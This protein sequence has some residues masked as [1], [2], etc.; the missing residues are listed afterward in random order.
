MIKTRKDLKF[1]LQE[2]A[3]A[4]RMEGCQLLKYWGRLFIGSESAH[5]YKYQKVLRHCEYHCNNGGIVNKMLYKYYKVRLYR[6]GFKYNIRIL[7]IFVAMVCQSYILQ[8][9]VDAL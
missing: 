7:R 9:V 1:Y 2:D 3:K 4:N 8:V 6:L 5:V